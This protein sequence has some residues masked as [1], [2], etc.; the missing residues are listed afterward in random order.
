MQGGHSLLKAPAPAFFSPSLLSSHMSMQGPPLVGHLFWHPYTTGPYPGQ[1]FLFKAQRPSEK[2]KGPLGQQ[3]PSDLVT[4][5]FPHAWFTEKWLEVPLLRCSRYRLVYGPRDFPGKWANRDQVV[6]LAPPEAA[7]LPLLNL[8]PLITPFSHPPALGQVRGR[9]LAKSPIIFPRNGNRPYFILLL[10]HH[11]WPN[12]FHW[13]RIYSKLFLHPILTPQI[14]YDISGLQPGHPS[15]PSSH[16]ISWRSSSRVAFQPLQPVNPPSSLEAMLSSPTTASSPNTLSSQNDTSSSPGDSASITSL[17][18]SPS[19]RHVSYKGKVTKL[20]DD[21]LGLVEVDHQI[22]LLFPPNAQRPPFPQNPPV[23][24]LL[25]L[26]HVHPLALPRYPTL[27]SHLTIPANPNQV[28]ILVGCAATSVTVLHSP[29][30]TAPFRPQDDIPYLGIW[31]RHIPYLT[32]SFPDRWA[33]HAFL[34]TLSLEA[35]ARNRDE[36][37]VGAIARLSRTDGVVNLL[38]WLG[39]SHPGKDVPAPDPR[40]LFISHVSHFFPDQSSSS[41]TCPRIQQTAQALL[42]Q[43]SSLQSWMDCAFSHSAISSFILLTL[44]VEED[45]IWGVEWGVLG[46]KRENSGSDRRK[47][48]RVH[49]HPYGKDL[50]SLFPALEAPS[51]VWA[52]RRPRWTRQA[53]LNNHVLWIN[54]ERDAFLLLPSLETR[55]RRR[56]RGIVD[57]VP[58]PTLRPLP[59]VL[60]LLKHTFPRMTDRQGTSIS[61]VGEAWWSMGQDRPRRNVLCR[62]QGRSL[63]WVPALRPGTLYWVEGSKCSSE[64]DGNGVE[65]LFYRNHT[66]ISPVPAPEGEEDDENPLKEARARLQEW[67]RD[68]WAHPLHDPQVPCPL[69]SLLLKSTVAPKGRLVQ[70]RVMG[71]VWGKSGS[72]S[73]YLRLWLGPVGEEAGR[74]PDLCIIIHLPLAYTPSTLHVGAIATLG[75]VYPQKDQSSGLIHGLSG[76]WMTHHFSLDPG[77][78]LSPCPVSLLP[79]LLPNI[80]RALNLSSW[81]QDPIQLFIQRIHVHHLVLSLICPHC[82]SI[83]PG[84]LGRRGEDRCSCPHSRQSPPHPACEMDMEVVANIEDGSDSLRLLIPSASLLLSLLHQISPSTHLV[85]ELKESLLRV[86]PLLHSSSSSSL[87]HPVHSTHPA[88]RPLISSLSSLAGPHFLLT[89]FLLPPFSGTSRPVEARKIQSMSLGWRQAQCP[90]MPQSQHIPTLYLLSLQATTASIRASSYLAPSP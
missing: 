20:I 85:H 4:L 57:P 63:R 34:Q 74:I 53:P 6:L 23:G 79:R 80:H 58:P 29:E 64:Q 78:P 9:L 2:S 31:P 28:F 88:L 13:V 73:R 1:T 19:L 52:L 8:R 32:T 17:M 25:I 39:W 33:I 65:L 84:S 61:M 67:Q 47:D 7:S 10:R 77:S 46:R 87:A 50:S 60:F 89:G 42:D 81:P 16:C 37:G 62:V 18:S 48:F 83:I 5:S 66:I 15:T 75:D 26:H 14:M 55:R 70:G 43:R 54:W 82:H 59:K 21:F 36:E 27:P 72:S 90:T 51:S 40:I 38:T 49:I 3:L 30:D 69:S 86:G 41:S 24:S 22:L 45:V 11:A 12:Q 71:W 68:E 56:K 76:T 44:T 35:Q